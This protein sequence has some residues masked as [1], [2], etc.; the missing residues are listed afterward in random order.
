MIAM[1]Q[2][3]AGSL[4]P[5]PVLFPINEVSAARFGRRTPD[6]HDRPAALPFMVHGDNRRGAVVWEMYTL[7]STEDRL[8]NGI[9][10]S[11]CYHAL[12]LLDDWI[13]DNFD[14]MNRAM[15]ECIA[16]GDL[17]ER[18]F[19]FPDKIREFLGP[20]DLASKYVRQFQQYRYAIYQNIKSLLKSGRLTAYGKKKITDK[21]WTI[22]P[23]FYFSLSCEIL[24][25]ENKTIVEEISF[26]DVRVTCL[27]GLPIWCAMVAY[28]DE[29][30]VP[31][32]MKYEGARRVAMADNEGIARCLDDTQS[33]LVYF[34][35]LMR[36]GKL[37]SV[38]AE[39][40]KPVDQTLWNE[41]FI[42]L[43][44]SEICIGKNIQQGVKVITPHP[45]IN[46][47][48]ANTLAANASRVPTGSRGYGASD[49]LLAKEMH[50]LILGGQ[51]QNVH[52]AA[53]Q[54]V[55]KAKGKNTLEKSKVQRLMGAYNKA[56][57]SS[58]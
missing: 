17:P 44:Q 19:N 28:G 56:F 30:L 4:L 52:Q 12:A 35:S 9:R 46:E 3:S 36:D 7:P 48:D 55:D 22:I 42:C 40:N 50:E 31:T 21:K 24:F 33:F 43:A 47:E 53:Q 45:P 15:C 23:S 27:E 20:T 14:G 41:K 54:V 18:A 10:L 5:I 39:T 57:G 16:S 2:P 38:Y 51:A 37:K 49:A 1:Q 29:E 34:C 8:K 32:L 6:P 58:R 25:D 11:D 13:E 26:I